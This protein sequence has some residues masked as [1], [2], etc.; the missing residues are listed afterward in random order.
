MKEDA[1]AA[2]DALRERLR[3]ADVVVAGKV[4]ATRRLQTLTMANASEHA[5]LWSEA[6]IDPLSFEKGVAPS[7]GMRIVYAASRD[8][9]W[10]RS[11]KFSVGQEGVW[12]LRKQYIEELRDEALTALDR[13]DSQP[14]AALERVRMLV[15][16]PNAQR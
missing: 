1:A 9:K 12:I 7:A 11:P 13:L 4:V 5:P 14:I 10:H 6:A 8:I 15:R 16:E 3:L 2:D